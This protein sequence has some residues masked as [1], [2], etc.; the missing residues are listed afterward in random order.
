MEYT[1]VPEIPKLY[2]EFY[3]KKGD[4]R[5][6]LFSILTDTFNI[7]YGLYPGSFVHITPSF[8]ISHMVYLDT[9]KRCSRFFSDK[10]TLDYIIRKKSYS[11]SPEIRFYPTDFTSSINEKAETF[12]WSLIIPKWNKLF[13]DLM[14][15]QHP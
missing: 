7:K 11:E 1:N 9:D 4:E 15:Q 10:L 5:S 13:T 2:H 14:T 3:V 8:F 6:E 12:D